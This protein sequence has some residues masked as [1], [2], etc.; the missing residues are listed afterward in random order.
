MSGKG[1]NLKSKGSIVLIKNPIKKVNGCVLGAVVIS[2][3]P[4]L[5]GAI[6][7]PPTFLPCRR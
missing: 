5:H 4:D 6:I 3:D 7:I 2:I 1:V